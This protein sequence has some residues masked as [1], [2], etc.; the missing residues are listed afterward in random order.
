MR[1]KRKKKTTSG[2]SPLVRLAALLVLAACAVLQASEEPGYSLVFCTVFQGTGMSVRGAEVTLVPAV[3]PGKSNKHPKGK[4]L[5]GVSD[6]R[7]EVAFRVPPTPG[8]Y[9]VTAKLKGF[10]PSEK[11][12]A[13]Q[14]G[15]E[16]IDVTLTLEAQSK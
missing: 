16:R 7:G 9:K 4:K 5:E 15:G 8:H 3:D 2:S 11:T 10:A 12:V 6:G 14:G 1:R 13:V